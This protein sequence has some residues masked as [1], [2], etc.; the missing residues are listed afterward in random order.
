MLI[1]CISRLKV[2]AAVTL[3]EESCQALGSECQ[4]DHAS[5]RVLINDLSE[6]SGRT[7]AHLAGEQASDGAAIVSSY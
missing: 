5:G 4:R 7:A 2:S 3:A 6:V 1:N